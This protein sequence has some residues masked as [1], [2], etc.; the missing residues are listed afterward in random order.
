MDIL[1]KLIQDILEVSGYIQPSLFE[2]VEHRHQHAAG[3]GTG[4]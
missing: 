4:V 2:G 1:G 3:V